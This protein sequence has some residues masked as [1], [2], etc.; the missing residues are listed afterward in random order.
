M[1]EK[2]N[3]TVEL[4]DKQLETLAV[5]MHEFKDYNRGDKSMVLPAMEIEKE[6]TEQTNGVYQADTSYDIKVS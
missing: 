3:F 5:I 2:S 1:I 4:T 6:L